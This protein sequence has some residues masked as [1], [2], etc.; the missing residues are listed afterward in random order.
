M[1][2]LDRNLLD[3]ISVRNLASTFVQMGNGCSLIVKRVATRCVDCWIRLRLGTIV[4]IEF[5]LMFYKYNVND[6]NT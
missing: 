1:G 2:F 3:F 6:V 4:E 5:V